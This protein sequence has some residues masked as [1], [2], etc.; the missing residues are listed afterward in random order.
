MDKIA[1]ML[2]DHQI[3]LTKDVAMLDQM[4][5]MNLGHF[6]QLS[7]YIAAGKQKLE[8]ARSSEL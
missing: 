6:R 4:Y 8:E 7:M 3:I 5:Q 1:Q 2:E